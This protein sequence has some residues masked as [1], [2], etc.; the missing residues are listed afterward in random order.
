MESLAIDEKPQLRE[1]PIGL[2]IEEIVAGF[3]DETVIPTNSVD[4]TYARKAAVLNR[5]IKDIGMGWYQWQLFIVIGF[6]WASDN[7]VSNFR[8]HFLLVLTAS[9]V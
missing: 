9:R 7:L 6:G 8:S 3:E 1:Q 4:I 2:T 5:A